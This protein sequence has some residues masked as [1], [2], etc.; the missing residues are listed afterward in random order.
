MSTQ[1]HGTEESNAFFLRDLQKRDW[2]KRRQWRQGTGRLSPSCNRVAK[3]YSFIPL[4]THSLNET[5][6]IL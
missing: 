2:N 3:L 4:D 5:L 6:N 1:K